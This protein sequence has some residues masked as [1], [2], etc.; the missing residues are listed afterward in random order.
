MARIS[1]TSCWFYLVEV[2]E[3]DGYVEELTDWSV[4]GKEYG[5][6]IAVT[7]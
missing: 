3:A 7:R 4:D 6:A 5:L 2:S 1:L